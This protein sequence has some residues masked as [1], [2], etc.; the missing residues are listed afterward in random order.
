MSLKLLVHQKL[1]KFSFY[2]LKSIFLKGNPM[3]KKVVSLTK[4]DHKFV[5]DNFKKYGYKTVGQ[6][7]AFIFELGMM[8]ELNNLGNKRVVSKKK[9]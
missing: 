2:G 7:L 5:K 3:P 1:L 8:V 6:Y 9:K 4:S